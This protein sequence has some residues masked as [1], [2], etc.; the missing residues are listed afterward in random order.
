MDS[1]YDSTGADADDGLLQFGAAS[2]ILLPDRRPR[3]VL[4]WIRIVIELGV[5]PMALRILILVFSLTAPSDRGAVTVDNLDFHSAK[6]SD[7]SPT[8]RHAHPL[9]ARGQEIFCASPWLSDS[10]DEEESE[11]DLP[12]P[13]FAIH[14]VGG[15]DLAIALSYPAPPSPLDAHSARVRPPLRC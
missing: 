14:Q 7:V 12:T 13:A 10:E 4:G 11:E 15:I 1:S 6:S 9:D 3:L 5:L 2:L 8:D